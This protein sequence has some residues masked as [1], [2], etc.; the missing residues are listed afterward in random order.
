MFATGDTELAA[1]PPM[2]WNSWNVFSCDVT[3]EDI[4]TAAD[5]LVETGLRDAGYEYLVVDDCWMADEVDDEGRLQ[6]HAEDFPSGIESLAE[7]VHGKGLKFGIY[8][9]AGTRTCQGLPASLGRERLHA[10]QFADWGV[11][12]LKYDNCGDHES[13]DAIARYSAMGNALAEVDRDIVYSICEWGRNEPWRWGRNAG[14]HLWRA[15]HDIVAKWTTDEQEF[16]LGIV[17]IID[18]MD[19]REMA[20]HH[21]PG[22]WND[23]DMLQIGNGPDS[24]QSQLEDVEIDRALTPAE[25]RTHFSFWCLFGAPLMAGNDL[26]AM[27]DWT[28]EL[29]TNEDAIAID[30]DPLGI[31]GTRDGVLGETEVW[32]KRLAGEECAVILFN[33]GE[34][35]TDIETTVETVDMPV[36]AAAY[37]VRDVWN[38]EIRETDGQLHA[39]VDPHDVAMFRVIPE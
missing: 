39:T 11:D 12:Y 36:D 16:G 20:P 22:G 30:Q 21:G 5:Q 9:S 37:T 31:Q 17:D 34:S 14:G 6:P 32:S 27:D 7:Y 26:A 25:E 8:S 23:P 38:D 28:R 4:R 13:N 2:G 10:R 3:E 33:R 1:T 24:G 29:L 19:E 35:T 18:Q 15:T